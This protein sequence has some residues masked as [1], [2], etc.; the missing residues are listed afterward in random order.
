MLSVLAGPATLP[1]FWIFMYRVSPFTYLVEGMLVTGLANTNVVC[2][3][4]EYVTFQPPSGRTCGEYTEAFT[5]TIGGYVRNP[6]ATSDCSFCQ[7]N[8]T[9]KYL[10]LLSSS[11]SHRWRD[12]GILWAFIIFN[13]FGALFFYWWARVPRKQKVQESPPPGMSRQATRQKTKESAKA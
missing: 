11:Y 2:S 12:F 8:D 6:E 3:E 5:S 13:A 4:I 9:N 10:E 7:T 1:G